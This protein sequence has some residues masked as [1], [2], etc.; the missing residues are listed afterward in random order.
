MKRWRAAL[1]GLSAL[2]PAMAMAAT[3]KIDGEVYARRT[4][5]LM[6]P[7]IEGQWNFNVTQLAP[8]GA[9]VVEGQVV[10]AFDSSETMKKLAEKQSLL[11]EKQTQLDKL[12]L[13]LAARQRDEHLAT[14]QAVSDR[15][16]A[17]RKTEQPAELIAG[18]QYKKLLVARR[19]AERK[20]E[21]ATRRERLAASQRIEEKRLLMSELGQLQG[22][23]ARLQKALEDLQVKAPRAGLMMHRSNWQ[24]EKFDVGSQVWR[25]QT[26]AEIPDVASLAVRAQLPERDLE[27]VSVGTLARIVI[28][29]AA[30]SAMSGK[31]SGIG[32]AVRSKSQVQP[33]PILDVEI[34][35]DDRSARLKPGQAVRVELT[36]PDPAGKV[37]R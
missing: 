17:R 2:L 14:A 15:D 7:V 27:R 9:P 19:Q 10:V 22:D 12:E 35:L 37:R 26:V 1:L 31:V 11:K 33:V 25:G 28:E 21:L 16:K 24:G 8:D 13:E 18:V 6:P 23:V 5:A 20:A 29:G 36:V 34:Q 4:A 32:H 30:G 3:L